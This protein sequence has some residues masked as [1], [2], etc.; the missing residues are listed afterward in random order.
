MVR[1]GVR[2]GVQIPEER[3][4]QGYTFRPTEPTCIIDNCI[5]LT[6]MKHVA[7][8]EG[9]FWYVRNSNVIFLIFVLGAN[10]TRALPPGAR[11][12]SLPPPSS[13]TTRHA[14]QCGDG[15]RRGCNGM[16]SAGRA[17]V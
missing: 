14:V 5:V 13:V 7:E 8:K 15:V 10:G 11:P 3:S 9:T 2:D 17:S 1:G 16:E 6:N 4:S 12:A